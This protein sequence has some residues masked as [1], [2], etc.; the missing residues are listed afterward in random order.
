MHTLCERSPIALFQALLPISDAPRQS[1]G[2]TMKKMFL[3]R[4]FTGLL[5]ASATAFAQTASAPASSGP[6]SPVPGQPATS[7]LTFDVASVRPAAPIDQAVI[8]EGLR[9][10]RRPESMQIEGSRATF[11]YMA[12]KALIAYAYKVRTYQAV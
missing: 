10:G 5:L 4:V 2:G 8:M 9:A 12:L 7:S 1:I 3:H 6:A 11:K